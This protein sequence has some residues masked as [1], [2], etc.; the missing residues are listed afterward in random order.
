V[1]EIRFDDVTVEVAG[2]A[3]LSSLSLT[4]PAGSWCT[5]IGPNGAGKSTLVRAAMG[6]RT[7]QRGRVL[8]GGV[9]VGLATER[10]RA[11]LAAYVPQSPV[12]PQ[13]MRVGDYVLLAR[14]AAQGALR[15]PTRVDRQLALSTIE[16]L[17]L[18]AMID[19]D[20]AT[21]SGGEQ[22]R[23]VV[24][25]ALAQHTTVLV[26]DEPTTGLDVRH[27]SDILDLLKK[28][29]DECGLTVL[30]TLHDLTLAGLYADTLVLL[31]GGRVR[32]EGAP[33]EVLR[34][35]ALGEAYGADLR[36][37]DVDGIDV[38]LPRHIPTPASNYRQSD[39]RE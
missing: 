31:D 39:I 29:V 6:L 9:N 18:E 26:V 10:T 20:V 24:A 3:L 32:R 37:I 13:G 1:S 35:P 2:R 23:V 16:R 19:R 12:M 27:Q 33:R 8:I 38:V 25:R 34:D 21:L 36:V 28:E 30:A 22:Q 11:G 5:V 15:A 7:L 4:I 17:G 14:T